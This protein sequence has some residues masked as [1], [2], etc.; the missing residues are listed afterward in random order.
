[1]LELIISSSRKKGTQKLLITSQSTSIEEMK[2]ENKLGWI[3]A[4]QPFQNTFQIKTMRGFMHSM[5]LHALQILILSVNC[6][7]LKFFGIHQHCLDLCF[8]LI[9]LSGS[10]SS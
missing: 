2:M 3:P 4:I 6:S 1:M 9:Y 10:R 7:L 8:G 5:F